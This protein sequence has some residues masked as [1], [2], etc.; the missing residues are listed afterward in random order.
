MNKKELENMFGS[1]VKD[2]DVMR[3]LPIKDPA[4]MDR[5]IFVDKKT[6]KSV[7][8]YVCTVRPMDAEWKE[9]I[10]DRWWGREERCANVDSGYYDLRDILLSFGGE[11]VCF[12]YT[13]PDLMD[14]LQYGQ[15]WHGYGAVMRRGAM[16]RCHQN[17]GSL[18]A[19]SK[20][21][22]YACKGYAL[23]DDGMWRQHSWCIEKDQETGAPRIIE[24]TEPRVLYFGFVK[25]GV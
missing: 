8:D 5:V 4:T 15:L 19:K 3:I 1:F 14:I 17:A 12:A 7:R 9:N 18:A 25:P 23:S 24:T 10:R 11:V 13:E 16:S 6:D 21:Q 22:I 20:G 2:G